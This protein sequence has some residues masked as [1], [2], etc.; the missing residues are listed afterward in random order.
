MTTTYKTY[1][2]YKPSKSGVPAIFDKKKNYS[3]FWMDDDSYGSRFAGLGNRG[4]SG[5][6]DVVRAIK[7]NTYQRAIANFVQILTKKAIPVTF[8]GSTSYT[9]GERVTISTDIKDSNFDVSVGLALH[10]A[11]HILLTDFAWLNAKS[12]ER[13]TFLSNYWGLWKDVLN[14]IE[15]R[16][17]D[18]YVFKTSPGYRAYYHK[19]YDHYWNDPAVT[20]GLK[21]AEYRDS[22]NEEH[23]MFHIINSL[24]PESDRTALPGL[25]LILKLINVAD[26]A[27]LKNSP[28]AGEVASLVVAEI[29]K[30]TT[31]PPEPRE[32]E[33]EGEGQGEGDSTPLTQAEKDALEK[34]MEKQRKFLS[35]QTGKKT[36]TKRLM[37]RLETASNS[38]VDIQAVG[39]GPLANT[40]IVYDLKGPLKCAEVI[41]LNTRATQLY[42]EIAEADRTLQRVASSQ[43]R[44]ERNKV[45]EEKKDIAHT[46]PEG[47]QNGSVRS[48]YEKAIQR[49]LEMG[50]LLGKKLQVR[51]ES[52]D[53]VYNRL[54]S[55]SIDN[56]RL[57]QAG[58]GI[59]TVF[60]QTLTDNYKEANLHISLD[61]SSSMCGERWEKTVQMAVAIA[62]AATYVQNLTIQISIRSSIWASSGAATP[63]LVHCYDS[64]QNK[65]SH[66]VTQMLTFNPSGGTPEGLCYEAMLLRKEF[67]QGTAQ[68]DSYFLNISDG[69]P[70]G[71]KN[72]D[73]P[74]AWEHTRTQINKL[75]KEYNVGI[76][77]FFVNERPDSYSAQQHFA[78]FKRMYSEKLSHLVDPNQVLEIAKTMNKTF[79][80]KAG[81]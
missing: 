59:E 46:L 69:E 28:E 1:K 48:E 33:E 18:N 7:L 45:L 8:E 19:M 3:S 20:K 41:D 13:D 63:V 60:K 25:D 58:F 57:A 71:S 47:F 32:K 17:I 53:L 62:K 81:V 9:N 16:R 5:S 51:N 73:G 75:A 65:L 43:L 2:S 76:M 64:K 42:H 78:A 67:V 54:R 79:L 29:L 52:R 40:V 4:G 34:A 21:S 74:R 49:G 15:D 38:T 26:I 24:N 37:K 55:G 72:Y 30:H 80:Q 44:I 39:T 23:Y 61:G 22:T 31:T 12:R 35:G 36:A 10:E 68:K 11:S 6:D 70:S 27:R 77:S 66:F 56:R 14:W 50:G